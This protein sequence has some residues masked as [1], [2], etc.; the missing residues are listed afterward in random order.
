M[1]TSRVILDTTQYVRVNVGY[2]S[3]ILQAHRDSVRIALSDLQ[4]AKSNTA[5]HTLDE[6][7]DPLPFPIVDTNVWALALTDKSSLIVTEADAPL[8]VGFGDSANLD[9]FSRL[10]TSEPFGIFDN[11]NITSRNRNQWVEIISGVIITYSGLTGVFQAAEEIRG[12]LPSKFIA[13][14]TIN[15]DNG[16]DTMNI[17]CNHNDFQVGD[18][19]TG[20]TS[21]ATA[22]VVSVGTGSNIQH[23]YDRSS[24]ILTTGTGATDK[25]IRQTHRYHAYVPGKSNLSLLTFVLGSVVTNV[26]RRVGI[27]DDLNGIFLE[28]TESELAFV[29]RTATSG[30]ASDASRVV[31]SDWNKDKLDGTGASGVNLDATKTQIL[32]ID[33]QWLGVGRVRIG[34]DI[35]SSHTLMI[36]L[37]FI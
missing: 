10:R 37:S 12:L 9:A 26:V 8:S 18:T 30:S 24:V 31:Q 2:T 23:S 16:T 20:Q 4:P 5:F 21:G 14:G 35:M 7:D 34:F 32:F 3:L 6:S 27:F 11:K 29:I 33:Y 17:D 22:T 19:I 13:I 1:A 25:A 28:Q 15:T 36:F